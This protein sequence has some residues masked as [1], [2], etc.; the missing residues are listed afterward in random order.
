MITLEKSEYRTGVKATQPY[1]KVE[2]LRASCLHGLVGVVAMGLAIGY[3][4][5]ASEA[6]FKYIDKQSKVEIY[7]DSETGTFYVPTGLHDGKYH[8]YE[9]IDIPDSQIIK[10]PLNDAAKEYDHL[11]TMAGTTFAVGAVELIITAC[12]YGHGD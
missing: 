4:H 10:I 6:E 2:D 9:K 11:M 8:G 1:E 7:R 3:G 12:L 5:K